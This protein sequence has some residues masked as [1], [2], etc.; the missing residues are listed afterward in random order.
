MSF[1]SQ[2]QE[3]KGHNAKQRDPWFDRLQSTVTKFETIS[4]SAI[5]DIVHA[6]H[7]KAN[8]RRL[9]PLMRE[10]GYVSIMSRR[11]PPGG[12]KDTVSRG[13]TRPMRPS[14]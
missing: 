8:A 13:W 12:F 6:A 14:K 2:M 4:T 1:A 5:L 3:A 7:T 11:L 10:L 9:A